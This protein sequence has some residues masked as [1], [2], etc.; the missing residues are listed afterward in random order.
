MTIETAIQQYLAELKE[1]AP[2]EQLEFD[3]IVLARLQ[4]YLEGDAALDG[5]ESIRADDLRQFVRDWYR[6]GEDVTAEVAQ[7][8][9]GAVLGWCGWL[10][11]HLNR[12]AVA[13]PI[14]RTLQPLA[15]DLPRAARV[16]EAL[17]LFARREDLGEA[18]P[19]EEA[20]GGSPLGT[21]SAGVTRVVRPRE[22]DYERA[23]E[24]TFEVVEVMERAVSLRSAAREQLGEGLAAPV[25]VPARAARILRAGDIMHVEIAPTAKGW[26]ILN[27]ETVYPGGLDD[28]A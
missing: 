20:A 27:V 25:T 16:T 15:E 19:V 14:R 9:V 6:T 12:P 7:R 28:R 8:L 21:I 11:T 13:D 17:R 3:L 1:S 22:I 5:A 18:I 26:E 24:D 4:E 23:E 2:R 10:D